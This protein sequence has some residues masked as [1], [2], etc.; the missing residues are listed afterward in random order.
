MKVSFDFDGTLSKPKIQKYAKELLER[1]YDVRV[2]TS[3]Y[4]DGHKHLYPANP[5]NEDMYKVTDKLGIPKHKIYFTNRG[6]KG[7]YIDDEEFI[8]HIDDD[9]EEEKAFKKTKFIMCF[10]NPNWKEECESAIYKTF[11][12]LVNKNGHK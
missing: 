10:G 1:G 6:L 3:R 11:E 9:K 7:N 12:K 4:D 2:T 8:F 5:T